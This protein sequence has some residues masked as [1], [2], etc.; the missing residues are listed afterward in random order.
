MAELRTALWSSALGGVIALGGVLAA[1]WLSSKNDLR[2]DRR[3]KLEQ[4][5]EQALKLQACT[6]SLIEGQEASCDDNQGQF[7]LVTLSYLYFP[8]LKRPAG[9]YSS[10]YLKFKHDAS[11]CH[12]RSDAAANEN[13]KIDCLDK[14]T[15][16][17]KLPDAFQHLAT[18]IEK[19]ARTLD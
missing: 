1:S 11:R 5:M 10:T 6:S 9:V 13:G 4:V 2:S 19:I 3:E 14:L 17:S 8:E 12:A 18:S 15:S 7:R 16:S